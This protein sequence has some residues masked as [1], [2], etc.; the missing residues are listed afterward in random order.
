MVVGTVA[1]F[2]LL[3]VSLEGEE[4]SLLAVAAVVFVDSLEELAQLQVVASVLVPKYVAAAQGCLGEV[5]YEFFLVEGE[6]GETGHGIAEH[7][8]VGE[9]VYYVARGVVGVGMICHG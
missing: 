2:H 3:E 4:V 7:F 9:A 6:V 1:E 8:Y 5:I